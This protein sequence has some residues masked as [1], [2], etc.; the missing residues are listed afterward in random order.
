MATRRE[1]RKEPE[2]KG[3]ARLALLARVRREEPNCWLCGYPIDLSLNMQTHPMGSTVDEIIPRSK[4][5][6]RMR[7]ARTRSNVHHC[8]RS[9][10]SARG[11]DLVTEERSSRDW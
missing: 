8:H 9:C 3:R 6:D 2:L 7:A 1:R 4:S 11:N 5:V 10:N